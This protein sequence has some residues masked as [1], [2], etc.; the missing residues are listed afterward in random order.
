MP[1]TTWSPPRPDQPV[2]V[3]G[4][5]HGCSGKL[6]DLLRMIDADVAAEGYTRP[7]LVFVGDYIDRGPNS[8]QVLSFVHDLSLDYRDH[9]TCL[10]GNH[11]QMMLDF[12]DNPM[13]AQGWLRH[14][15][16]QTLQSFGVDAPATPERPSGADLVDAASDLRAALGPACLDWLYSLPAAWSSGNLWVVHAGAD[17]D[18]P[19]TAQNKTALIWGTDRFHTRDRVDAQWVVAGHAPVPEPVIGHG[20]ILIDT[21]AVYGG[22]L[23]AI[24]VSPEGASQFL[25]T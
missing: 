20:R 25:A 24:R 2:Y 6:H 9:V 5:V 1:D 16:L 13:R 15:G 8:A 3:V 19:M 11:E 4:D 22:A 14:G 12:L 21:G 10:I 18:V 23:T 7:H 17:P